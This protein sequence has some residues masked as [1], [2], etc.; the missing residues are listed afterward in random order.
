MSEFM[1]PEAIIMAVLDEIGSGFPDETVRNVG[2]LVEHNEAGLGLEIL[3]SQAF[4]YGIQLS[5]ENSARLKK[6]AYLMKIPLSQLEG[7]AE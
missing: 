6:A 1:T 5:G 2:E 7:L 4:E 3:C